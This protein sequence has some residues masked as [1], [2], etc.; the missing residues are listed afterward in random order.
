MI[1]KH[2]PLSTSVSS[3]LIPEPIFLCNSDPQHFVYSFISA[4]EGSATQSKAQ[5]KVKIIEVDTAIK[6]KI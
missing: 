3:N 4:L 2:V 1:G 6:N 5:R